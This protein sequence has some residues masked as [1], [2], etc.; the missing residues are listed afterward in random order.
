MYIRNNMEEESSMISKRK[1]EQGCP[2]YVKRNLHTK[3]QPET[4]NVD[5][6]QLTRVSHERTRHREEEM[7]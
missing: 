6:E 4:R 1:F 5:Y 3:N 2:T 7:V